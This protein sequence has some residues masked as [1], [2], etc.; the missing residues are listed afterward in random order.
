M[1]FECGEYLVKARK[2]SKRLKIKAENFRKLKIYNKRKL[3]KTTL[4]VFFFILAI[5]SGTMLGAYMAILENLPDIT[6]LEEFKLPVITY[7]YSD[8]GEVIGEYAVQKRVEITHEEI[9]EILKKAIIATEDPRFYK[10]NGIDFLGILRAIKEDLKMILN[11]RRLHGGSTISQQVARDIFLHRRQEVRRK[12][13]EIILALQIESNY[14]KEEIMTMYC[15]QFYLGHGKYGVESASQ[16]FFGKHVSE[17]NL[18]E[19]A[20]VAGIFRGPSVY[21][22]YD[23]PKRT[24]KRRNHVIDRMIEEEFISE[25]EG[26]R[27]KKRPLNVLSQYRGDSK[28]AA[29]FNEEVRKYLEQNYGADTLYKEGLRVYTTLNSTLQKYAEEALMKGLRALDKRQGW[30]KEKKNLLDKGIENL[31]ELDRPFQDTNRDRTWLSTWL[32]P[33]VKIDEIMEAVVLSVKKDEATV[34]LKQ[35]RGKLTNKDIVWTRTR[36]LRNLI[37]RGDVIQVKIKEIDEEKKELLVSLD[38][39]PVV[40]GAFI[41]IEPQT[42]QI[43]AMV[44]GYSFRRLK[45]NQAVQAS[46]QSGSAIKPILYTAALENGYTPATTFIDKPTYFYDKWSRKSYSPKNY[47]RKFE[48]RITLR[49]GLEKSRNVV[50]AK[51]LEYISP[52]TGVEYCRKFGITSPVYPY[53]S[54]ALGVFEV[55]LIELVSAF[56][57]FPNKGIRMIPY[58]ITHIEDKGGNILEENRIESEE[59]ISPQIAYIMTTLLQGVIQRGTGIS[60]GSLEK[61][62]AGKTGTT[63]DYTDA[64][65]IGFSPSLCAGV[66]VGHEKKKVSIGRRQSGAV[67]ALPIWKDFFQRIIEE[68][69]RIA[70]ETSVEPV[71]EIFVIPPNLSFVEIDSKTGLLATPNCKWIM[72]EVFLPGT[73]P[74]RWCT[75]EDHHMIL[76]YYDVLKK[77]K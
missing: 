40:E 33:L 42:G 8:E 37:K 64:W 20:L 15:N 57:T 66:W 77:K 58:F 53:L 4:L 73:E 50:T 65:F 10:H 36:D 51:L 18:E 2:L 25:E 49:R 60:A 41:A 46:R 26:E 13:K 54:M 44:G 28:F 35:Y 43:K 17:L 30:R 6:A 59:V 76:D 16:L 29:Y 72:K 67:A 39:E 56:S 62:L 75:Y 47:D 52:H 70:E 11:P 68:E 38:Q 19:S 34:K 55:R 48:G 14:S 3:L 23:N 61:P 1:F 21:S 27:V 12:L 5:V 22:P 74:N 32:K 45:F 63:D 71:E 9:P 31:E 69:K 24:L 7:I